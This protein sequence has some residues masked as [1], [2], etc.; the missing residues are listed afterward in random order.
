MKVTVLPPALIIA[1][2]IV[3]GIGSSRAQD[4][5]Y[6]SQDFARSA[7]EIADCPGHVLIKRHPELSYVSGPTSP[8]VFIAGAWSQSLHDY[9]WWLIAKSTSSIL[10]F[11]PSNYQ[12]HDR[13]DPNP[14]HVLRIVI[15]FDGE[16]EKQFQ[17]SPSPC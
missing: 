17:T 4:A 11:M 9:T 16:I 7:A 15:G 12:N 6:R 3:T 13:Q 5:L 14:A 2:C 10:L 8:G 1:A